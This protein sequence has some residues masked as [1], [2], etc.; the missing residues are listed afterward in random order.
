MATTDPAAALREPPYAPPRGDTRRAARVVWAALLC[1]VLGQLLFLWRMPLVEQVRHVPDDSFF[2]LRLAQQFWHAREF[3]FDGIHPTYGFQ[4]LWQLLLVLVQPL[5]GGPLAF[6]HCMLALCAVLHGAIGWQLWRLAGAGL[7]TAGGIT[8]ALAWGLNPAAMVW[9]W[10][11]KENALY[12]LLLVVALRQAHALVTAAAPPHGLALRLGAVLGAIVLTRANALPVALGIA[13]CIVLGAGVAAPLRARLRAGATA[14]AVAAAVA[15]PW[16]L[17]AWWH[18]GTALPTSGTWKMFI[19]RGQVE[20][21]WGVPWLGAGHF[22]RALAEWPANLQLLFAREFGWVRGLV[23][24]L[25]VVWLAALLT[26]WRAAARLPAGGWWLVASLLVLALGASFADQLLLPS[27]LDYAD[28]YA[29]APF[30]AMPFLVGLLGS[31]L[32]RCS[33]RAPAALAALAVLVACALLVPSERSLHHFRIERGLL[34]QPPRQMQLLEMGL[35]AGRHLPADARI[36]IWDPGIV[37]YF[38]QRNLTSLDPLMNSLDYQRIEVIGDPVRY[39]R[40][41]R[42][43]Y[44][45][46]VVHRVGEEWQYDPMPKGTFDILWMPHPEHDLGWVDPA[47]KKV[48]YA[49]V[50]PRDTEGP[51]FLGEDDFPC[52]LLHPNDPLQRRWVTRDRDALLRGIELQADVL[53]VQLEAGRTG[54]AVE[55]VD[56][57]GAVLLAF[58]AGASGWHCLD[59]RS[60]RGK[61]V[62]LRLPPGQDAGRV[63]PQAQLV[64]YSFPAGR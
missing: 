15:A 17:W 18:F 34:V 37:S 51:A 59:V 28:W 2:Y 31:A 47:G 56:E 50:R 40:E 22:A 11:L 48:H 39:V 23:A 60:H 54:G 20:L 13:V 9:C 41:N 63:V 24:G 36:G 16:Y 55:L 62:R 52:G 57:A 53:R 25:A 19:V 49:I 5:C 46:G 7:G 26:G 43:S 33:G 8:A 32:G 6:F 1:S 44:L 42:I 58:S 30:V 61:R 27:Y 4:P 64:D 35:W 21:G 3:T 29:V 10:G 14:L 45:M 12:A 38:S